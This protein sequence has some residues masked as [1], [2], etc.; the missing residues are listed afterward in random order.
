MLWAYPRGAGIS[1]DGETAV[2]VC[3]YA[4]KIC[5]QLGAHV[6]KIKPP[7]DFI[8]QAEAKKVFEKYAIPTKTMADR[9]RHCV[10]SAFNGKRIV[11]FSGGEAK[12]TDELLEEIK[13]MAA[14]GG[15]GASWAATRSSARAP[16]HQASARRDEHLQARGLRSSRH[17]PG[18]P[19]ARVRP[20]SLPL[21]AAGVRG[22]PGDRAADRLAHPQFAAWPVGRWRLHTDSP[23]PRRRDAL[24]F[25]LRGRSSRSRS[26]TAGGGHADL[27]VRRHGGGLARASP[28]GSRARSGLPMRQRG[29]VGDRPRRRGHHR[30][31]PRRAPRHGDRRVGAVADGPVLV[32]DVPEPIE[33]LGIGAFVSPQGLADGSAVVLD[34]PGREMR[35][36]SYEDAQAE[37]AKLDRGDLLSPNGGIACED[38]ESPIKGLAYVV[39]ATIEGQRVTLLVDTGAQRTDLLGSSRAGRALSSRS[40]ANREQMFA[41]SGQVKTRTLKGAQ[42][43]V[44][45][46]SIRTDIDLMPGSPDPFCPRDGV[47]SMD[48]LSSCVLVLG[49]G[50][51]FGKCAQ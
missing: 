41:A 39:P 44:G 10:Q 34:M 29:D 3:A 20:R 30:D 11:I 46:R 6:I 47:V 38:T 27:D 12:G 15:F 17:A 51:M 19:S 24:L 26:S 43:T 36:S 35:L 5:A 45:A 49:P 18:R 25:E 16:R 1:K 31:V 48:I 28:A 32:T 2:D 4:A 21:F 7:K 22:M 23:R 33:R 9:V 50:R 42:V 14:G 37:L 8:E 13:G 40:S